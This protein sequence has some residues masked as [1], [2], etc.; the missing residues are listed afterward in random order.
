[1]NG[2]NLAALGCAAVVLGAAAYF[3]NG[4]SR[5][6]SPK[7]NGR[8]ILPGLDVQSVARIEVGEKLSLSA[9]D[10]GWTIDSLGGYPADRGKIAENLLKLAELKVGQVARGR[11]LGAATKVVLKDAAGKELANLSLGDK[12]MS[13]P[14]GQAAMYGGGGYPDGRY[15]AF[16]GET[17]LV[18]EPLDQFDGDAR[19]WC[20][21]RV[22]DFS[23][24]DVTAVTFES[25]G[26]KVELEK[27]T[28]SVWTLKGLAEGEELDSSKTYSLDSGLSYL[29]FETVA[30]ASLT[31]EALGFATGFVY[32]VTMKDGTNSVVHTAKIGNK[33]ENGGRYFNLDGGKWNFVI[34]SYAADKMTKKRADLVKEKEKPK[35][36]EKPAEAKPQEEPAPAAEAK[37][38][39]AKK[40]VS[41]VK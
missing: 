18:K 2:K 25:G 13:K 29:D 37:P 22:A 41:D 23:A 3:V 21:T 33:T 10:E 9:G 24:S 8:A 11:A 7:L 20:N 6:A 40:E 4:S 38:A 35:A 17:V 12:H 15:I 16:S 27:G 1:M 39:E 19:K 36:E 30:D 31:D 14:S 32:T 28:N 26:E 5:P 34:P